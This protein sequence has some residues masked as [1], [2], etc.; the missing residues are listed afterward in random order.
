MALEKRAPIITIMGHVDHGKTTLLDFI[1]H[2]N[3]AAR[4]EGGITQHIGAYQID[5][6]GQKLTFIDTP[7][8]AAFNKM[9]QRGAQITDLV[10]LVVAA[11]DGVMPQT[12]ESIRFIKESKV[13]FLVAINK[14]DLPD[15]H[16]EV[17]KSQLAEHEVLVQEYGGD[18]ETVEISAKN[19]KGVD[20]LLETVV[21]MT[22]LANLQADP[23]AP[24]EAV[25][26]ESTKDKNKGSLA[27][28]IVREGTL[29]LRQEL[30]VDEIT[31]RVRLLTNEKGQALAQAK[32][33]EPAEIIGLTAA[34]EVGSVIRDASRDYSETIVPEFSK[35]GALERQF[36]LSDKDIDWEK[37]NLDVVLGEKEQIKLIIKADVKGTL[38][39]IL[40][41]LD[42]DSVE[43]I[44]CGVGQITDQDIEL[45]RGGTVVIIAFNI[46]VPSSTKKTAKLAGVKIMEYRIIYHLI[47]DLQKQ[48]LKLIDSTIDEVV[49][50]EAEVLQVFEMKGE[51]IAG[52]RVKTGE[53]KKNDLLHLKRGDEIIANPV[54]KSMKH[55][56]DDI[57]RIGTKNE[58]GL[59][60][61]NKK[62]DFQVG[63]TI[64]A[65]K[66]EE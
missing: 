20:K 62:L 49:T 26:I 9:R 63:D 60:F 45:A 64:V 22:E 11:N 2:S 56:K 24:L 41:S 32:P 51:V 36:S 46:S 16:P 28:V 43:V 27:R 40:Q 1:R 25:V 65:Y 34:P 57:D 53:I 21:A 31:G 3:I 13:P 15:L 8:H 48:M 59:T 12:I 6:Q 17:V 35:T 23:E 39:A 50:G 54:I 61:K 33:G 38:E 4:E 19:G 5:F 10:I 44:S 66:K 55:G 42:Q 52:L 18:V 29:R 58:G 14:M 37:V 47:E 30:V 7:G